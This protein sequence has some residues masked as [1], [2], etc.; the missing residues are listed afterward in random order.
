MKRLAGGILCAPPAHADGGPV[1]ADRSPSHEQVGFAWCGDQPIG[2]VIIGSGIATV[3]LGAGPAHADK[4]WPHTD[5][6]CTVTRQGRNATISHQGCIDAFLYEAHIRQS[7][8]SPE[9]PLQ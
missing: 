4:L 9:F 8:Q 5:G 6:G 3:L 2:S 1:A 7:E